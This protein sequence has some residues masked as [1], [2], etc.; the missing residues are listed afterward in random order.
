MEK[1]I[2]PTTTLS[3]GLR[4]ANFSS[5]H[6]FHFVDGSV[7]PACSPERCTWLSMKSQEVITTSECGRWQDIEISFQLSAQCIAQLLIMEYDPDVDVILVPRVVKDA[8]REEQQYALDY[9]QERRDRYELYLAMTSEP[10]NTTLGNL[11]K[12]RTIR[13]ADRVK[14]LNHIDRF[15][16]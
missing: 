11:T 15:C 13:C 3:N 16:V 10:P 5:P 8:L 9:E 7:L 6:E 14:K 1:H 12:V 4:V 2:Y